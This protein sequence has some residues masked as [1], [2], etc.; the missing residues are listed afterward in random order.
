MEGDQWVMSC[1]RELLSNKKNQD[2]KRKTLKMSKD[3]AEKI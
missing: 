2:S 1:F 3:G